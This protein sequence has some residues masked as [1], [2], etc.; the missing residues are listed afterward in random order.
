MIKVKGWL[1]G[2]IGVTLMLANCTTST[3]EKP[4][5]EEIRKEC[6]EKMPSYGDQMIVY[7]KEW[8][9]LIGAKE[10]TDDGEVLPPPRDEFLSSSTSLE[11]LQSVRQK[12]SE[13]DPPTVMESRHINFLS[14]MDRDI[15]DI[16]RLTSG[17]C[18]TITAEV[19]LCVDDPIWWSS[20]WGI[21]I[22]L[23]DYMGYY[24]YD[25][26]E[27]ICSIHCVTHPWPAEDP[28]YCRQS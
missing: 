3:L 13:L 27:S 10:R 2:L 19:P 1:L 14:G 20:L 15:N 25:G 24:E 9:D 22:G 23:R 11:E 8:E 7:L 28:R 17:Y 16:K 18:D 4:A 12:V 26:T 21:G 5:L 6:R